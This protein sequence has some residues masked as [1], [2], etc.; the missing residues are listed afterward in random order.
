[1]Q[2]SIAE[3]TEGVENT[4]SVKCSIKLS[5]SK[6]ACL[7]GAQNLLAFDFV[8]SNLAKSAEEVETL[9]RKKRKAVV[10]QRFLSSKLKKDRKK[11]L[12]LETS[13]SILDQVAK[14]LEKE[15]SFL[16]SM[17]NDCQKPPVETEQLL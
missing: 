5:G 9:Q 2:S 8:K 16:R 6:L 12:D 4:V 17:L 11:I 1:M 7:I 13:V 15:N 3:K 14:T 10:R